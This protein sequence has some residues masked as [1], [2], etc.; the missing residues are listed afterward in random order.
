M[1]LLTNLVKET[2]KL[3][4]VVFSPLR[5]RQMQDGIMHRITNGHEFFTP[6]VGI[7]AMRAVE[8]RKRDLIVRTQRGEGYQVRVAVQDSGVGINPLNAERIFDAFYTTKPG[9]MGMGLSIS[10][11]IVE[12]HGGRL[13][14][15]ANDVPAR[16]FNSLFE[17][18]RR[19]TFACQG[20]HHV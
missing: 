13:W 16:P 3:A 14:A 20:R 6:G 12:S 8:D 5:M 11:S 2:P 1:M 7:Q 18:V 4:E 17:N 19:I 15:S 9:G 10:R